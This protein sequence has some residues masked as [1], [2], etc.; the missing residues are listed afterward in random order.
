MLNALCVHVASGSAQKLHGLLLYPKAS[1]QRYPKY[2][3][4]LHKE[5]S[6]HFEVG[7]P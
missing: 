3:N 6:G 5:P 1:C 2:E 4:N 7:E